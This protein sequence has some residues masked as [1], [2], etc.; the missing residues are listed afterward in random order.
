MPQDKAALVEQ[1]KADGR[2][3]CFVGDGINDALALGKADVSV[4]L[5]GASTLATDTAQVVL[6][7]QDLRQLAFLHQLSQEFDQSLKQL[8][9]MNIIPVGLVTASTFLLHTGIYTSLLVWQ[10]G[11]LSGI[12]MGFLPLWKHAP[13]TEAG[14]AKGEI[15]SQ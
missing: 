12:S 15:A 3:V 5:R 14:E 7:S 9:R 6:M 2:K 4:S 11:M 8:F 10:L 13:K 1:L